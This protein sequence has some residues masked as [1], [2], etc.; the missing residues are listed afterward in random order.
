MKHKNK[1]FHARIKKLK[2]E[3]ELQNSVLT[4]CKEVYKKIIDNLKCKNRSL[5]CIINKIE[6]SIQ[7]YR[8]N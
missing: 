1:Y 5:Q 7:D 6:T 2:K 4:F 3:I 8:R